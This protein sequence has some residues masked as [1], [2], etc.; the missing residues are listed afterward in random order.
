MFYI[1]SFLNSVQ[2][3]GSRTVQKTL[4]SGGPLCWLRGLWHV[5]FVRP[6]RL[7]NMN[8]SGV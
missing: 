6:V 1:L 3:K 5:A 4:A 2:G 8:S 7:L